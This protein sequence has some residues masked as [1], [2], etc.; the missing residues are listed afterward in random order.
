MLIDPSY[1]HQ[2]S[3]IPDYNLRVIRPGRVYTLIHGSGSSENQYLCL[4][5]VVWYYTTIYIHPSDHTD[6]VPAIVQ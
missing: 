5:I 4:N 2:A 6:H 1:Q 3:N